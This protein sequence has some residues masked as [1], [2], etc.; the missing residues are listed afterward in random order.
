MKWFFGFNEAATRWFADMVEV[1]VATAGEQ[2][3][4]LEPHCLYDGEADTD[5]TRW[6]RARGVT[7]HH[8]V[9]PFRERLSA[10]DIVAR[11][12]ATPYDPVAA[13]GYYLCLAIPGV[14]A[15]RDEEYVLFTD[16]D[17]MFTGA[18]DTDGLRPALLMAAPEMEDVRRPAPG[19][20]GRGFSSGVMLMHLPSM[21]A[22]LP[23]IEAVLERDG[24]YRFPGADA[25][26]DQGALNA[27]V[28][29]GEWDRLPHTLN[30][31]PAFGINPQAAIVHWHGPKPR[32]VE[33]TVAIG[34]VSAPDEAMRWLLDAA[35]EA[36]RHYLQLFQEALRRAS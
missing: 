31:R 33:K 10:P 22:L 19:D 1:A 8:A 30:W 36:Y 7:V 29:E 15:A 13:R 9:A 18:V 26:Y 34:I 6:L 11:N 4:Q 2:A 12:A 20:R 35:P 21:R 16:C 17:V 25:T 24:Y 14:D 5:L 27:A 3:P 32:H 28:A 23:R